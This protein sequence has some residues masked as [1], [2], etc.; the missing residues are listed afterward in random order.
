MNA[1][2]VIS[3]TNSNL[4]CSKFAPH[5]VT[6]TDPT[7]TGIQISCTAPTRRVGGGGGGGYS[8]GSGS[9]SSSSSSHSSGPRL[10]AG[11]IAGIV[12]G[13]VSSLASIC[14]IFW[15]CYDRQKK[16]LRLQENIQAQQYLANQVPQPPQNA[17]AGA[18]IGKPGQGAANVQVLPHV[19]AD[20]RPYAQVPGMTREAELDARQQALEARERELA[21]REARSDTVRV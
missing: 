8:G 11:T 16:K 13:S 21:E 5:A 17:L 7:K 1:P 6:T 10:P 2:V 12:V 18:Y 20:I 15:L 3:S 14:L 9:G 4:N 19:D